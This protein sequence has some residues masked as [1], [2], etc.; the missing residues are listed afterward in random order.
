M[1]MEHRQI[2]VNN[3]AYN[4]DHT[5]NCR[6]GLQRKLWEEGILQATTSERMER[7]VVYQRQRGCGDRKAMRSCTKPPTA[8]AAVK[9]N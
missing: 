7:N 8:T 6:R 1:E 2:M 9:T 5:G 3:I 4:M